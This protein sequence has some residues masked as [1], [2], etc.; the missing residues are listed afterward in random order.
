M[1]GRATTA[2]IPAAAA[3]MAL[4]HLPL[5][6]IATAAAGNRRMRLDTPSGSGRRAPMSATRNSLELPRPRTVPT[7]GGRT[8]PFQS[9]SLIS[10]FC[11]KRNV[12]VSQCWELLHPKSG[13][14]RS[15]QLTQLEIEQQEKRRAAAI[16]KVF[17]EITELL[18]SREG[19]AQTS[20]GA[21]DAANEAQA[22]EAAEQQSRAEA[23]QAQS[24]EEAKE[25]SLKRKGTAT[26]RVNAK[27]DAV[28]G[29]VVAKRDLEVKVEGWRTPRLELDASTRSADSSVQHT[30]ALAPR[31]KTK[32]RQVAL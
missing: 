9:T 26:S 15:T 27:L 19:A 20:K 31:P 7:R 18:G 1:Q 29:D 30:H 22:R 6:N 13:G 23:R 5:R 10:G 2:A 12:Y 3:P 32:R 21:G 28:R 24:E 25:R 4:P 16:S 8:N 11:E 14:P 17:S